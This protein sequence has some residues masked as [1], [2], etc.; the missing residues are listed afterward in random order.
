MLDVVL[1]G[2]APLLE[3]P[4]DQPLGRAHGLA[5][6]ADEPSFGVP[7][8]VEV[9]LL[10]HA[11]QLADVELLTLLLDAVKPSLGSSR[12]RSSHGAV[13]LGAETI[14]Q[15]GPALPDADERKHEDREDDERGGKDDPFPG[16]HELPPCPR[17]VL[18]GRRGSE[19]RL[20]QTPSGHLTAT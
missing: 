9:A 6:V 19:T 20:P 8:L 10:R 2:V 5:R 7:P 1:R 17:A 12:S 18:P 3:Q 14:L 4:L 16:L 15:V 11:R 13:V